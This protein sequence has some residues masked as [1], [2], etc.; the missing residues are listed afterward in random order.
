MDDMTRAE[1]GRL[2]T[3]ELKRG[4]AFELYGDPLEPAI[5]PA[6][7]HDAPSRPRHNH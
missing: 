5:D 4:G 6:A 3:T 1:I 7:F 2:L